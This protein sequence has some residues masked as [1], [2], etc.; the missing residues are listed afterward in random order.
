[1]LMGGTVQPLVRSLVYLILYHLLSI[2]LNVFIILHINQEWQSSPT[3]EESI[4]L[5][6]L[7]QP[8]FVIGRSSV[9]NHAVPRDFS[10][11]YTRV[12]HMWRIFVVM[13]PVVTN[14]AVVRKTTRNSVALKKRIV[15]HW[16]SVGH[17]TSLLQIIF[18]IINTSYLS[19][20]LPAASEQRPLSLLLY[21]V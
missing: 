13:V 20:S 18:F 7:P 4:A 11:V 21:L 15:P 1:M 3:A 16:K 2:L 9:Q 8:N 14:F 17:Y 10:V 12:F 19:L 6:L 5:T